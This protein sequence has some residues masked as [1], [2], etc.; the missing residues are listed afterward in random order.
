MT[1]F[2]TSPQLSGTYAVTVTDAKNRSVTVSAYIL[3]SDNQITMN[4]HWGEDCKPV[5]EINGLQGVPVERIPEMI[6]VQAAADF[7]GWIQIQTEFESAGTVH[8]RDPRYHL[9]PLRYYRVAVHRP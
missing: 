7:Q 9:Y 2:H 8:C 5:M 1:I 4:S 6:E 3:V